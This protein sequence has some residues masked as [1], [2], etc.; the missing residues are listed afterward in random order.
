MKLKTVV[1]KLDVNAIETPVYVDFI[2]IPFT[3][4]EIEK[5]KQVVSFT[6]KSYDIF[7]SPSLSQMGDIQ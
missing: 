2:E 7:A 3:E 1:L 4:L 5:E 6:G